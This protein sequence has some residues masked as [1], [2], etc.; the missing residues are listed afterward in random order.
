MRSIVVVTTLAASLTGLT[1]EVLH[2]QDGRPAQGL[3]FW[4]QTPGPTLQE[5]ISSGT[6]A[7]RFAIG[8]NRERL[9]YGIGLGVVRVKATEH[10]TFGPGSSSDDETSATLFQIGPTFIFDV[11]RSPDLRTHGNITAGLS[12]GRL[13]A[14]D[15]S[16]FTDPTGTTVTE[17]K[18]SGT[19]VGFHGALGGD[20]FL[21]PHFALG[22]EAGVQGTFG[23]DI[24]EQGAAGQRFGVSAAGTYAAVRVTVV[25]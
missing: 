21:H 10:N 19:L 5:L 16:E 11:W 2:G 14:T 22:A 7:P 25:F 18:T 17:T 1:P 24:E 15:R 13:S 20:Y 3:A 4:V 9:R 12:I 6:A 8:F 23:M